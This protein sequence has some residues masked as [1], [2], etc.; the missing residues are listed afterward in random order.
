MA[1]SNGEVGATC[2]ELLGAQAHVWNHIFQ[3]IN[4][5]SLKC[6]VQL[7]IPD[8][9][10]NHGQPIS[11]FELIAGLNVHPSKAHFISRLMRILVHSDFFAQHHHVHH[12]HDNVEEEEAVVLYSL[13]PASGL[14]LEDGPLNTTPFLLM[15]LDPVMTDPFHSMGAW[16]QMNGGDD[17]VPRTPFEV[18]NGMPFWE[19]SAKKPRFGDLFNEAMEADSK[20]IAR[21]VVEE[22]GGVFE[23]LKSL[24]DV[25]GGTGTMAKAIANA[26]PNI[27]CTVFDQPYVVADLEG[28]THNLGFVRGDMFDKIPPA[29]AILLKWI[30]HD[31]NDEESVKILKKC[32]EAMLRSKNEGRKKIIIIDIVVGYVNNKMLMDKK[33]IETQLMLDMLMI[34]TVTS[35]E[36]SESEWEKIFLAAGFTHYN[37]THTLGLRSL[38]EVYL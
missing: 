1:L 29:N 23:G 34:S 15:I 28:T 13:T 33:S 17:L 18:A 21:A 12:N 24:V 8:V 7:G 20:L 16:L 25:G 30:L 31:W 4:S 10:H 14:F 37:I 3:F 26:F 19:L 27:N 32:R 2:H 36:R 11:L 6:A 9:I 22:C 35:K 5:M 38:I